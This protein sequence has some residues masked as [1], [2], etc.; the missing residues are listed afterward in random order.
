MAMRVAR[1]RRKLRLGHTWQKSK[2]L[3]GVEFP[4]NSLDGGQNLRPSLVSQAKLAAMRK[5][6]SINVPQA[7][8]AT[9]KFR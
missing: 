5:Q 4:C 8:I 6:F 2:E 7:K 9:Q 3:S 1:H